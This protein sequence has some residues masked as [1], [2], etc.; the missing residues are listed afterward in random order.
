MTV[1]DLAI[2][3]TMAGVEM[4]LTAGGVREL[5][6]HVSAE[7][8]YHDHRIGAHHGRGSGRQELRE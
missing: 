6:W 2:S 8:A 4:R 5:H 3:K 1:R 7:W